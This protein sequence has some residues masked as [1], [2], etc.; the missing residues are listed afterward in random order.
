[1]NVLSQI[2]VLMPKRNEMPM[3]W[4]QGYASMY[5]FGAYPNCS[6]LDRGDNECPKRK[7]RSRRKEV[8]ANSAY[9]I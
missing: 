5:R 3:I 4:G 2:S 1:M 8:R 7:G 6:S 9:L